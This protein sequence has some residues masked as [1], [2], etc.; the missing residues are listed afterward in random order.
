MGTPVSPTSLTAPTANLGAVAPP[1]AVKPTPPVNWPAGH[2]V[3][4]DEPFDRNRV[5]AIGLFALAAVA[6]TS[7]FL[8]WV[9]VSGETIEG[10]LTGWQRNDGKA[11]VALA[12]VLAGLSGL[13]FVGWKSAAVKL[14]LIGS[15]IAMAVVAIVDGF[16]VISEGNEL[17]TSTFDVDFSIGLGSWVTVGVGALLIVLALLERSSWKKF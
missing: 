3:Q 10:S 6:I 15:G 1:I 8:P 9:S 5:V 7:A 16:N 11:I 17:D 14:I 2:S 12:V 4:V 13:L